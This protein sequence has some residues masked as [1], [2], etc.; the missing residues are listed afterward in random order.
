MK[1]LDKLTK[2]DILKVMEDFRK[3]NIKNEITPKHYFKLIGDETLYPR[4]F[5][6]RIAMK[7]LN[8][9]IDTLKTNKAKKRLD[10]LFG[11][12]IEHKIIK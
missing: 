9:N 5:I 7:R 2:N 11:K 8:L 1:E 4:R 12:D 3:E 6:V 10:E